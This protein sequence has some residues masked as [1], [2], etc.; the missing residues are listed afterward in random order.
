MIS[1]IFIRPPSLQENN[2]TSPIAG[3]KTQSS[4]QSTP[5]NKV[6]ETSHLNSS[7]TKTTTVVTV[8]N[9]PA[10]RK[11]EAPSQ[12]TPVKRGRKEKDKSKE[13]QNKDDDFMLVSF[14]FFM[15][16]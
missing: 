2:T 8:Q 5:L 7:A 9:A 15:C 16:S 3:L 14:K 13:K 11:V 10:K 12:T 1:I 4:K 6:Q